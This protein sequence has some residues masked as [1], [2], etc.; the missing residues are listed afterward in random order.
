MGTKFAKDLN[1]DKFA[2][3]A[4]FCVENYGDWL[5][6][7]FIPNSPETFLDIAVAAALAKVSHAC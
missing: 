4:A 2:A 5:L 1:L 3:M 6:K 7:A